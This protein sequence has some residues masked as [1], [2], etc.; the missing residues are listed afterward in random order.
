[1]YIP[2]VAFVILYVVLWSL[3]HLFFFVLLEAGLILSKFLTLI[4]NM[5]DLDKR[6]KPISNSEDKKTE[7]D[8]QQLPILHHFF[9]M[10]ALAEKFTS[11]TS[12]FFVVFIGIYSCLLDPDFQLHP[13]VINQFFPEN[14]VTDEMKRR[15]LQWLTYYGFDEFTS[16]KNDFLTS[17]FVGYELYDLMIMILK[18]VLGFIMSNSENLCGKWLQMSEKGAVEEMTMHISE[19]NEATAE[20]NE[21]NGKKSKKIRKGKKK[22]Q[23]SWGVDMWIHH[24]VWHFFETFLLFFF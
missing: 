1:M 6:R 23:M 7:K 4:S 10:T 13:R 21:K 19:K 11:T 5:F 8:F 12:S 22:A 3:C 9:L 15:P 18:F 20:E 2:W 24:L 16:T 14:P 17:L